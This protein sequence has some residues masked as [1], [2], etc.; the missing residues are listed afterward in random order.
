M[1]RNMVQAPHRNF[2]ITVRCGPRFS[3]CTG[4]LSRNRTVGYRLGQGESLENILG[5]MSAV[6]EGVATAHAVHDLA[7]RYGVEMPIA[8]EVFGILTLGADPEQAVRNLM[9]RDPKPEEAL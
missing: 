8:E 9:E 2:R 4:T 3:T 6:A 1:I 5:E 7:A